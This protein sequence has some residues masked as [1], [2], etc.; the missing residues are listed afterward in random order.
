MSECQPTEIRFVHIRLLLSWPLLHKFEETCVF[1]FFWHGKWHDTKSCPQCVSANQKGQLL[2]V[3][4]FCQILH[5]CK[6]IVHVLVLSRQP[7]MLLFVHSQNQ[8]TKRKMMWVLTVRLCFPLLRNAEKSLTPSLFPLLQQQRNLGLYRNVA[9]Q[10]A[11][12]CWSCPRR[13]WWSLLGKPGPRSRALKGQSP[14][15]KTQFQLWKK[16]CM[17]ERLRKDWK[18]LTTSRKTFQSVG[19]HMCHA[20]CTSAHKTAAICLLHTNKTV[21]VGRTWADYGLV[22]VWNHSQHAKSNRKRH[23]NVVT[24]P[25]VVLSR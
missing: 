24:L 13:R 3:N 23:L 12:N 9:S 4:N 21:R 22:L 11:C 1:K 8:T 20:I 5:R 18:A 15:T 2:F 25:F 6:K 17:E 7:G 10:P 16:I 19:K 14:P